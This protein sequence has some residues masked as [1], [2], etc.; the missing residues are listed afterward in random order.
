MPTIRVLR[1]YRK[2]ASNST[3]PHVMPATV[4]AVNAST[5]A[6]RDISNERS[7]VLEAVEGNDPA[8][9]GRDRGESSLW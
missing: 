5:F 3:Y 9:A 8:P 7:A 6:N 2:F 4:E 1:T